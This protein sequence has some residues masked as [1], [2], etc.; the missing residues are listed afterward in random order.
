MQAPTRP[1]LLVEWLSELLTWRDLSGLLL[2]RFDV[3]I[4]EDQDH[5]FVI[6]GT[7]QGE[8]F[9]PSRHPMG[10]EVKGISY[11]GLEVRREGDGWTAQCVVDV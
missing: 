9:D 8:P 1:L 4:E 7:V 2:S 10:V 3:R 11:S 5:G 6:E